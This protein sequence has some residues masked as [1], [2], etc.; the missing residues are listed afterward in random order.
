MTNLI[1]PF[2]NDWHVDVI[3][4]HCHFLASRRSIGCTHSLVNITLNGSLQ[5]NG[6]YINKGEFNQTKK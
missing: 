6:G 2:I 1:T 4:E 3:H 5:Q